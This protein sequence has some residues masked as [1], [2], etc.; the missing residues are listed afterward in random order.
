MLVPLRTLQERGR[1]MYEWLF[2]IVMV[3][4]LTVYLFVYTRQC[5]RKMDE[6]R[7]DYNDL[8]LKISLIGKRKKKNDRGI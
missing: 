6:L 3:I 5:E 4:M 2:S 7:D 1:E 8:Y